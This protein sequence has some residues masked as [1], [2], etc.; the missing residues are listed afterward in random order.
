ML[1][2]GT[3]VVE[4]PNGDLWIIPAPKPKPSAQV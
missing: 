1:T 2:K 3:L 4:R